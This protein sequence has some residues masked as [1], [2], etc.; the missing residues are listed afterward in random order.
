MDKAQLNRDVKAFL[1]KRH[2]QLQK[3]SLEKPNRMNTFQWDYSY[4]PWKDRPVEVRR[5]MVQNAS[6]FGRT[7][8]YGR[9]GVLMD[10]FKRDARA[11]YNQNWDGC[12]DRWK[13]QYRCRKLYRY[14]DRPIPVTDKRVAE[15]ERQARER[16]QAYRDKFNREQQERYRRWLR[17]ASL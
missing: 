8:I 6:S 10:V 9:T 13:E 15:Y 1:R 14:S 3:E 17:R 11:V 12:R 16:E 5:E 7:W 4:I 2:R